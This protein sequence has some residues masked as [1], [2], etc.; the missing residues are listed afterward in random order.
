MAHEPIAEDLLSDELIQNKIGHVSGL[1]VA[2]DLEVAIAVHKSVW[3][4]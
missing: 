2:R 1:E 3:G 4:S